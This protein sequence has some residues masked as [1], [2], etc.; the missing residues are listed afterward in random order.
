MRFT[1]RAQ[2]EGTMKIYVGNLPYSVTESDLRSA[3]EAFGSVDSVD[4]IKD[5]YTDE[6]KGFGFVEMADRDEAQ[7]AIDGL[8]GKEFMGRTI[9]VN[10]A[11]P[12]GGSRRGGGGGGRRG[13]QRRF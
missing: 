6:S 7:K 10:E 8:N 2:K 5:R 12:R 3:F 9:T 13:G 4:I 11:R 1:A